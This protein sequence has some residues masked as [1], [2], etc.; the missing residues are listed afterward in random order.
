M[1]KRYNLPGANDIFK[2]QF[3]TLMTQAKY[4]Q[5]MKLAVESPQGIL[6]TMDTINA[7]K[8]VHGG[9]YLGKYFQLLLQRG[10][11]NKIESIEL[12]SPIL[13]R[14]QGMELIKGWLKDKKLD[15]SEDLGDLLKNHSISLALTAYLRADL[16][17]KVISC[18][19]SLAAQETNETKVNQQFN[20]ILQYSTEVKYQPDYIRLLQQLASVK[21]ERAKDFALVLIL[22]PDGPKVKVE[23]VIKVFLSI[24]PMGDVKNTTNV[25]LEYLKPLLSRFED[26]EVAEY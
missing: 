3:K 7:L 10:S 2:Q 11:L 19:L 23:D 12:C 18:F 24:G 25:L 14:G 16:P 15:T 21:P 8:Q 9:S 13:A 4:D 6:R 1:A 26:R 17:E 5:A 20:K 22:H